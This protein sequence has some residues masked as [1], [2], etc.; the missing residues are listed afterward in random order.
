MA[1]GDLQLAA[2]LL[3]ASLKIEWIK[4]T[5]ALA[6]IWEAAQELFVDAVNTAIGKAGEAWDG[7]EGGLRRNRRGDQ[8]GLERPP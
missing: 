4:G 1:G 7:A 8:R 2:Q 6:R 3:W 5:E